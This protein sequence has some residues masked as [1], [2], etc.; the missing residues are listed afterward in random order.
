MA[1][2]NPHEA[3]LTSVE[4]KNL[5]GYIETFGKG[6]CYSLNQNFDKMPVVSQPGRVM[7]L[8][9]NLGIMWYEPE[10]GTGRFLCPE[11]C[12][13]YQA[14][15]IRVG[16]TVPRSTQRFMFQHCATSF[17]TEI[18]RS[19]SAMAGQVGNGMNCAAVGSILQL[20][21]L[22]QP[23]AKCKKRLIIYW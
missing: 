6:R 22:G 17:N 9:R 2:H 18:P 5:R 11:E 12:A 15:P 21:F 8:I 14:L 20:G 13:L 23:L 16:L 19:R 3:V 1:A 4:A 10:H 7:T